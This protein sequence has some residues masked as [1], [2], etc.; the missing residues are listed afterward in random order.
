MLKPLPRHQWLSTYPITNPKSDAV[1]DT[2]A[3][4]VANP[5]ANITD[6][7]C[8]ADPSPN[9]NPGSTN[10]SGARC[11]CDQLVKHGRSGVLPIQ[12]RGHRARHDNHRQQTGM[13]AG[14]R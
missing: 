2:I 14:M 5:V 12:L 4:P 9:P 3:N 8:R 10:N 13:Q 1:T 6:P 11:N 7:D